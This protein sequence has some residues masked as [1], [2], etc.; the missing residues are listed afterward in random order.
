[1]AEICFDMIE[2][3]RKTT[4]ERKKNYLC[5]GREKYEVSNEREIKLEKLLLNKKI[6]KKEAKSLDREGVENFERT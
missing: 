5:V 4:K 2:I 6:K 1:M 3:R